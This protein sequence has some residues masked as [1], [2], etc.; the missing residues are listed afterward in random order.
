MDEEQREVNLLTNRMQSFSSIYGKK[1]LSS[2]LIPDFSIAAMEAE[3]SGER[4][5]AA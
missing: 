2:R 1:R 5:I 3:G 4:T